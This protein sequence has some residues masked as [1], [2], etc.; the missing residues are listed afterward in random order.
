MLVAQR[1]G[2]AAP[3]QGP[4]LSCRRQGESAVSFALRRARYVLD[5]LV[6]VAEAVNVIAGREVCEPEH[7]SQPQEKHEIRR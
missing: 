6:L 3:H 4:V 2:H 1:A 7:R 5:L